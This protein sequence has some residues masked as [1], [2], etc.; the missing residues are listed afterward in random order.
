MRRE[1]C[2]HYAMYGMCVALASV[3]EFSARMHRQ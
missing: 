2:V 3:D 1:L